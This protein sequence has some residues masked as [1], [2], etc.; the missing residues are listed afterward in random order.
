MDFKSCTTKIFARFDLLSQH[1]SGGGFGTLARCG[2]ID[3]LRAA[4]VV[5][6][7][8][9]IRYTEKVVGMGRVPIS[10]VLSS[11][12]IRL[13][14]RGKLVV[15]AFDALHTGGNRDGTGGSRLSMKPSQ[16]T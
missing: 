6:Y 13:K 7:G 5:G 8:L 14:S 9:T 10:E 11:P 16:I 3:L 12:L 2:E 1:A 4:D 15:N